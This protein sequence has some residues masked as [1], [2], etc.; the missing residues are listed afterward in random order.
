MKLLNYCPTRTTCFT[1]FTCFT[2]ISFFIFLMCISNVLQ[3]AAHRFPL[4]LK[5]WSWGGAVSPSPPWL[6]RHPVAPEKAEQR[7]KEALPSKQHIS[8]KFMQNSE[9]RAAA[10]AS[11]VLQ[12]RRRELQQ[13]PQQ[14]KNQ[15]SRACWVRP[16]RFPAG[17]RCR[18]R[19]ETGT[20]T[21]DGKDGARSPVK[22][23]DNSSS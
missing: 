5:V 17:S 11:S 6:L 4:W 16:T 12:R 8:C 19:L 23:P 21:G 15:S 18:R 22:E 13:T 3:K 1:C 9:S 14:Y 10:A 2:C 7:K 20:G